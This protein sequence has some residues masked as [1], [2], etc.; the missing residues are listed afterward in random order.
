MRH[1]FQH[2]EKVYYFSRILEAAG[3]RRG[4]FGSARAALWPSTAW[5]KSVKVHSG[6]NS[7]VSCP[8]WCVI[9]G[10][11]PKACS[12]EKLLLLLPLF[13]PTAVLPSVSH[14]LLF[15]NYMKP[16]PSTGHGMQ[17]TLSIPWG[18]MFFP[19]TVRTLCEGGL[20]CFS[21]ALKPS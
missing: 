19:T 17:S 16:F 1:F 15:E 20:G 14:E 7:S 2:L 21:A 3:D 4:K 6:S 9:N 13:L 10:P 8:K 12:R 11:L 5:D 18:K